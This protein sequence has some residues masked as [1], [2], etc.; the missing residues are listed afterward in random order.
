MS[1]FRQRSR[2]LYRCSCGCERGSDYTQSTKE[3]SV[4]LLWCATTWVCTAFCCRS[5]LTQLGGVPSSLRSLR[6]ASAPLHPSSWSSPCPHRA[7]VHA[8]VESA[9]SPSPSLSPLQT[10][11]RFPRSLFTPGVRRVWSLRPTFH[12]ACD[13]VEIALP[14]FVVLFCFVLSFPI[15]FFTI[16]SF[17]AHPP[18][19]SVALPP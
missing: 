10:H 9:G 12:P 13:F 3:K 14:F 19:W 18:V 11:T 16:Y 7:Y 1:R 6:L 17:S 2:L 5:C 4:I 15:L 8:P